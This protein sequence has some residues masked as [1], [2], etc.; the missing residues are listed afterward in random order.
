MSDLQVRVGGKRKHF[1]TVWFENDRVK[2]I[3]QPKLPHEFEIVELRNYKEVGEA[4]RNMTV[5]GA[6]AIG[7]S[8]GYG[9]LLA[10]LQAKQK[11]FLKDVKKAADFLKKTRP[12]AYD[13]FYSV[14]KML[15]AVKKASVAERKMIAY[16]EAEKLAQDNVD[17]CR[18][19]GE[20]GEKLI[21]RD[22]KI[23][24][25]CNAGWLGFVDWGSALAP[26]YMAKGRGKKPFV[27]VDETRPR[28]QG[29]RLTAWELGNE[30]VKHAII[31]DNAAGYYMQKGEVDLV[32]VGAD[33]IAANGDTA[34][35]IGT[36]EKAVLAKENGIPFYVAAPTSTFDFKC[37]NGK[38]IP[39]EGRSEEEVL[40]VRGWNG[41]RI[42]KVRVAAEG[43]KGFNP[44]FDAT[45]A[46]SITAF[47]TEKGIFK[48]KELKG[49]KKC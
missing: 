45:P 26:I 2:M 8:A 47:I 48:P 25:H 10:V 22:A 21:K 6:G 34:N 5:R 7:V 11:N 13:L 46:E 28:F 35:K 3:N 30:G 24:T 15:E 37:K 49:L 1:R 14:D 27:F 44:A 38:E 9:M 43:S 31:A 32:M 42:E 18:S 33:R 40:F 12:T 20:F 4:I 16:I 19:I 36:Y 29:A 17:A 41:K 39:I 23:L